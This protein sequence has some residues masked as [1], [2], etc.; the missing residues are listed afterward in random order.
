MVTK[1]LTPWLTKII[2]PATSWH[3][4]GFIIV[5]LSLLSVLSRRVV[6][7]TFKQMVSQQLAAWLP[8]LFSWHCDCTHNLSCDQLNNRFGDVKPGPLKSVF[9]MHYNKIGILEFAFFHKLDFCHFC[10]PHKWARYCIKNVSIFANIIYA[11]WQ[12]QY[13]KP[14][15]NLFCLCTKMYRKIC[16]ILNYF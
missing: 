6:S 11:Y 8:P 9:G 12:K 4:N 13:F 5:F 2:C 7:S 14:F 16:L 3:T 15:F 10:P 1:L